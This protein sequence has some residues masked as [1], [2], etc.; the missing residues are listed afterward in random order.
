MNKIV[1]PG[2]NNQTCADGYSCCMNTLGSYGCCPIKDAGNRRDI[3]LQ[4]LVNQ[5]WKK[6]YIFTVCCDDKV[7]CCPKDAVCD[8]K[9]GKCSSV[10][11]IISSPSFKMHSFK[12]VG[13]TDSLLLQ[14][15]SLNKSQYSRSQTVIC[16]GGDFQCPDRSTCCHIAGGQYGCCPLENVIPLSVSTS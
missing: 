3:I 16:P 5:T 7:H 4:L 6:I 1:C 2:S 15:T 14:K 9:A 13:V 11:L 12:Y 10:S 8:S